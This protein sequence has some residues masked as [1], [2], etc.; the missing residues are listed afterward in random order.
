MLSDKKEALD[1]VEDK[2]S[3]TLNKVRFDENNFQNPILR[4]GK[5]GSRFNKLI[6]SQTIS[7]I[8]EHARSFKANRGDFDK[9][10]NETKSSLYEDLS[11]NITHY[12]GIALSDVEAY[13][14]NME[15]FQDISWINDDNILYI[16]S[17]EKDIR[18]ITI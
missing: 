7:K 2:I 8:K 1:V 11:Q 6:Q 3:D 17:I 16:S 14:S 15:R 4:I 12:T 9:L 18:S 5:T 10:K 13:F